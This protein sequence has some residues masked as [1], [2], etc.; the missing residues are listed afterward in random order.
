[1]TYL[2]DDEDL[3]TCDSCGKSI[4]EGEPYHSGGDSCM[5]AECA[6][7]WKDLLLDPTSFYDSEGE[8]VT[9]EA[10]KEAFDA[11]IAAG[12]QPEDKMVFA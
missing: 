11:Y 12:G 4:P 5:C 7:S 1:M 10:A 9:R 8:S 2:E 6:P 3:L